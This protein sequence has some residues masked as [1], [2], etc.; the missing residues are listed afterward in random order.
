MEFYKQLGIGITGLSLLQAM[1]LGFPKKIKSDVT[2]TKYKLKYQDVQL[3]T[4]DGK[5]LAAWFIRGG[6]RKPT[7]IVGH[8]Y[9]F[10]KGNIFRATKWLYPNFNLLYYDHRSFGQ[11]SGLMTTGGAKESRD[12]NAAIRW[13]K[14]NVPGPY[15]LYGFSLSAAAMLMANPELVNG[16]FALVADSTYANIDNVINHIYADLGILG[17]PFALT[18]KTFKALFV[19]GNSPAKSISNLTLPILILHSPADTQ[20][21]VDNA[22][23]LYEAAN[24][25]VRLEILDKGDHGH[26]L[27]R[28]SVRKQIFQFLKDHL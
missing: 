11:S 12:V 16:A 5:K 23:E 15:G 10:D 9:P 20:I 27:A 19:G 7:L 13:V 21:P 24:G 1:R 18:T 22:R 17:W 4:E 6:E 2:P 26:S 14:E 28:M 3:I 25:N 8:G